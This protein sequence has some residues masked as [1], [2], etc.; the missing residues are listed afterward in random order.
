MIANIKTGTTLVPQLYAALLLLEESSYEFFLTGSR[1][2]GGYRQNSDYD[3]FVQE[4]KEVESYLQELGFVEDTGASYDDDQSFVKVLTLNTNEGV[5]QVQLIKRDMLARK[6]L[7]QRLLQGRYQ[8][9]GLP[10]DKSHQK[11]LWFLTNH[12]LKTLNL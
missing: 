10:G 3:F 9:C 7:A 6:E 4:G 11:E 8:G 5:V 12:I 2:F 1:L